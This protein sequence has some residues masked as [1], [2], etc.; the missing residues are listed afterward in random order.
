MR[1]MVTGGAGFIGSVIVEELVRAGHTPVVYDS[2]VKGHHAALTAGVPLITADV[3]ETARLEQALREHETEAVIHMA[4]LIAVG[5][6]VERPEV[7]FDNNVTGSISVLQAML[8]A[9]GRKIVFSSTGS[10]YAQTATPPFSE[11]TPIE[12]TNPYSDSKRMVERLLAW[13]ADAHGLTATALRYFNAAGA[14]EMHGEH[15][16]PETHLLPLVLDAAARNQPVRIFGD[17]YHT[18]DGTAVRDY[19]HV[20]DLAQAHLLALGR[21]DA[22]YRVYNVGTGRGYSVKEV[23]EAVRTVT[24]LP[25]PSEVHPR[26]PGD[27]EASVASS[28]LIQEEMGWR[29]RFSS[30]EEIIASAWQWRQAHPHGYPENEPGVGVPTQARKAGRSAR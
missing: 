15:H 25:V 18:P 28:R 3:R 19:I 12:P 30:L 6:S 9:G 14:T 22:G 17:D 5:E 24:G 23:I 20:R 21:T 10:V 16:D 29:P 27:L 13:M 7:Y 2:F 11:Q 8:G 4:G 26:R 1:V